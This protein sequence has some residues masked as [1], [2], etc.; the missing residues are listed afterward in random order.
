[1]LVEKANKCDQISDALPLAA[2]VTDLRKLERKVQSEVKISS[3]HIS[4]CY[5]VG[6]AQQLIDQAEALAPKF[7]ALAAA[8]E[9]R[10][11]EL[12]GRSRSQTDKE[13]VNDDR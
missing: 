5:R 7:E 9:S 6:V 11:A 4:E 3:W 8:I 13:Q 10:I 2:N 12:K 1:M